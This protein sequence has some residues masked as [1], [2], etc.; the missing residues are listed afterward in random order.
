MILK[1]TKAF[2]IVELIVTILILAILATISFTSIQSYWT[3]TRDSIRISDISNIKKTLELFYIEWWKYPLST[4]SYSV[5]YWWWRVWSQWIFWEQTYKNIERLDEL[6]VDPLTEKEYI[7]SLLN[8]RQEYEIWWI[9]EGSNNLSFNQIFN[10]TNAVDQ[11]VVAIVTWNYDWDM[12]EVNKGW[13]TCLVAV[14]SIISTEETTLEDI[15]SNN[16]F[17]YNKYKNL[18]SNYRWLTKFNLNWENWELKLVNESNIDLYCW[19]FEELT[20][21][22]SL[23]LEFIDNFQKAYSWTYV[24]R[25]GRIKEVLELTIDINNP[26][27]DIRIFALDLTEEV[28]K[29]A[30]DETQKDLALTCREDQHDDNWTCVLNTRWCNIINWTW[31][32]T[33]NWTWWDSCIVTSCESGY[34]QNW[35]TCVEIIDC[36]W[37]WI[38]TSTCTEVC[39]WWVFEEIYTITTPAQNWWLDCPYSNWSIRN[40]STS[41]NTQSCCVSNVWDV[42]RPDINIRLEVATKDLWQYCKDWSWYRLWVRCWNW[43]DWTLDWYYW[44][45]PDWEYVDHCPWWR[46]NSFKCFKEWTIQCDWSC[47]Y[48]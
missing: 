28:I 19:D 10:K 17:V 3:K 11:E 32:Q 47:N 25:E 46:L 23:R 37:S 6:P 2:T 13:E 16:L 45:E 5:T 20:I 36:I 21:N 31:N 27:P 9:M 18:P 14:P 1:K 34:T 48:Q 24:E 8:N 41:C 39:W 22:E 12:L 30:V 7:Y 44:A 33:W 35:N 29:K 42:C 40:W 4:N 15:V 26:Q 38:N 43:S